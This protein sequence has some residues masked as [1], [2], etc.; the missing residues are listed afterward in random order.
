M[1]AG[2]SRLLVR[3]FQAPGRPFKTYLPDT[4]VSIE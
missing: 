4:P 1:V 3:A 2:A